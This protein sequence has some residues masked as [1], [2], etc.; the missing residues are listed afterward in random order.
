MPCLFLFTFLWLVQKLDDQWQWRW[1][2]L[3]L[4]SAI[5][6]CQK[7]SRSRPQW[8]TA[9]FFCFATKNF[10]RNVN[11][12]ASWIWMTFITSCCMNCYKAL[13]TLNNMRAELELLS[14]LPNWFRSRP[15]STWGWPWAR[16]LHSQSPPARGW[17]W[18]ASQRRRSQSSRR[19][20]CF[21][22]NKRYDVRH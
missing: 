18:C 2:L 9:F 11:W 20:N 19:Q 3:R 1:R 12:V 5:H 10:P 22:H 4:I 16:A 6:S 15:G 8:W 21:K 14:L 17:R 13:A 7:Y